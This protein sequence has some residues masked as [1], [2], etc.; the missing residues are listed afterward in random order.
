MWCFGFLRSQMD[1][2]IVLRIQPRTAFFEIGCQ[3]GPKRNVELTTV[4]KP[5]AL[6]DTVWQLQSFKQTRTQCSFAT[7]RRTVQ[8]QSRRGLQLLLKINKE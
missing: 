4:R 8:L 3:L 7:A 1:V 2:H 5:C 6:N